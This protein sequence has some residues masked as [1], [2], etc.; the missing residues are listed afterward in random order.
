[1][2][3]TNDNTLLQVNNLKKYFPTPHG[4]IYAVDN[5]SF[6]INKGDTLGVVGE[7]GCGKSTLGRSILRL[8]EP[9]A[10]E[11]L[12]EGK[13]MA[14]CAKTEFIRACN[15]I[16]GQCDAIQKMIKCYMTMA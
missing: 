13:N 2:S 3:L 10:G 15:R 4:L 16:K 14:L 9:T 11:V 7:S 12:F 5:V 6:N 8:H 1:M